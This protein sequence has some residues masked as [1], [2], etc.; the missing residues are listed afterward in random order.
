MQISMAETNPEVNNT[1]PTAPT[2]QI[3]GQGSFGQQNV[4]IPPSPKKPFLTIVL[5]CL[6]I[7]ALAIGAWAY[8][9]R[10][11]KNNV[12]KNINSN[13][14][15][16]TAVSNQLQ[17]KTDLDFSVLPPGFP[18]DIPFYGLLE[19]KIN[20]KADINNRVL[21]VRQFTSSS[22]PEQVYQD[23]QSYFQ[24]NGWLVG[25]TPI[26]DGGTTTGSAFQANSK[27]SVNFEVAA[28]GS[29]TD[30]RVKSLVTLLI[31]SNKN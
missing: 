30:G 16:T 15:S 4:P 6:L 23:Y 29:D 8:Y 12:P 11:A 20:Y 26:K 19:I 1:I 5:V 9:A 17:N 22:T 31:F 21:G 27:L 7:I 2:P 18:Q 13:T 10:Q 3:Q 25:K 14:A 28:A 24:N